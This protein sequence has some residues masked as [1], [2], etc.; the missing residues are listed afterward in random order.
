MTTNVLSTDGTVRWRRAPQSTRHVLGLIVG[1]AAIV[2]APRAA[3]AQD[4]I[5]AS[6]PP[7]LPAAAAV[8]PGAYVCTVT[9][10]GE[11]NDADAVTAADVVCGELKKQGALRV[12]VRGRAGARVVGAYAPAAARR[13]A[14]LVRGAAARRE[15]FAGGASADGERHAGHDARARAGVRDIPTFLDPLSDAHRR[16]AVELSRAP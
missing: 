4:S 2:L 16:D 11:L 14:H 8:P 13:P 7:T 10:R 9:H 5:P 12:P 15:A 1:A 6:E 3:R